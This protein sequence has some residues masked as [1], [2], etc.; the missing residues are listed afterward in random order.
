M[1]DT[2]RLMSNASVPSELAA[3]AL[4]S[5]CGAIELAVMDLS[6]GQILKGTH[7]LSTVAVASNLPC[8]MRR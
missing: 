4:E 2:Q 1:E 8:D 7:H 3:R 6:I 5:H